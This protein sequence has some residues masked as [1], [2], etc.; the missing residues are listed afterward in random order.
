MPKGPASPRSRPGPGQGTH[1]PKVNSHCSFPRDRSGTTSRSSIG[2]GSAEAAGWHGGSPG[3]CAGPLR[4]GRGREAGGKLAARVRPR[5]RPLRGLAAPNLRGQRCLT[6]GP[7]RRAARGEA[8]VP[9][10][11]QPA[12]LPAPRPRRSRPPPARPARS[13]SASGAAPT[14]QRSGRGPAARPGGPGPA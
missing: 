2:S 4:E 6:A 1:L 13:R 11:H 5:H 9:P 8:R 7:P 12:A 3:R 10:L 14:G